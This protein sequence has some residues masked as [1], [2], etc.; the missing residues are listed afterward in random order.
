MVG[1]KNSNQSSII[2]TNEYKQNTQKCISRKFKLV[3]KEML[4]LYKNCL[5]IIQKDGEYIGFA[6]SYFKY[7]YFP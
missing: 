2:F 7:L 6:V 1:I 5:F 4:S 3:G